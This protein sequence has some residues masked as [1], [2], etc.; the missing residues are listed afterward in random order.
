[1]SAI[2][3]TDTKIERLIRSALWRRGFRFR[4]N[5]RRFA[6]S[7]DVVFP[8]E[9]VAVFCDSDFWHGRDWEKLQQRLLTNRGYWVP[10]I[11]RNRRRD[12][13]ITQ[14]LNAQGWEVIRLWE[15]DIYRDVEAAVDQVIQAV[16]ERRQRGHGKG[17]RCTS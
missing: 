8:T 6:G 16:K 1:M 5:D 3:S 9:Q 13:Q 15:S 4:K 10:K 14:E 11:E 17:G 12:E 7:P 2:R